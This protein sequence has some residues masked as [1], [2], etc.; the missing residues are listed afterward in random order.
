ML[1]L[2]FVSSYVIDRDHPPLHLSMNDCHQSNRRMAHS[3][4]MFGARQDKD[5]IQEIHI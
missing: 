4:Y 5:D 3:P 1:I 2:L